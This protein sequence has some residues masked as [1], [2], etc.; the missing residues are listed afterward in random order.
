MYRKTIRI[1]TVAHALV[2]AVVASAAGQTSEPWAT[3]RGNAHRTASTDGQAGPAGPKIL[4]ALKSKEQYIAA[5]LPVSDRLS[6]SDPHAGGDPDLAL[7]AVEPLD[8]CLDSCRSSQRSEGAF[9]GRHRAVAEGLHHA[10][11]ALGHFAV[12]G[13]K[14]DANAEIAHPAKC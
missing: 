12:G 4:W 8:R 9:E 5:P 7:C 11:T 13:D 1:L 6:G 14:L 3:Y 10:P 2:L